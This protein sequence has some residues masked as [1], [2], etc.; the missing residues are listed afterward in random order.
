M[1]CYVLGMYQAA[2]TDNRFTNSDERLRPSAA[3]TGTTRGNGPVELE[4]NA[5]N[6]PELFSAIRKMENIA[7]I[8]H[9]KYVILGD[10]FGG[11]GTKFEEKTVGIGIRKINALSFDE[12]LSVAGHEIGHIV[13]HTFG[14]K[15][16][17]SPV[18]ISDLDEEI[19]ADKIS[20]CLGIS[21]TS[22]ISALL[23]SKQEARIPISLR[24]EAIDVF[25]VAECPQLLPGVS[26]INGLRRK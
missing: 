8:P 22:A 24:I 23:S 19:H 14:D 25:D 1:S 20:R 10:N 7:H 18:E 12:I 26:T 21:K 4:I 9:H 15:A 17:S 3:L 5:K 13:I 6:F 16:R 2:V 11:A